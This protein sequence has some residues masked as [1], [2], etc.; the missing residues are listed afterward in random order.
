LYLLTQAVSTVWANTGSKHD[1][2]NTIQ[3]TIL[4]GFCMAPPPCFLPHPLFSLLG[5]KR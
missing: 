3:K 5:K 4:K 2:N 1:T